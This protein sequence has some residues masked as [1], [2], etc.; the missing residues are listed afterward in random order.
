MDILDK[1]LGTV[2]EVH[3]SIVDGKLVLG[4]EGDLDLA[5]QLEKLKAH[6]A[7]SA[8]AGAIIT[9]AEKGLIAL[10]PPAAAAPAAPA[11]S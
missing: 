6:F 4:V 10:T 9:A 1:K 7:S 2:G 11:S 3:V 8:F 5:A